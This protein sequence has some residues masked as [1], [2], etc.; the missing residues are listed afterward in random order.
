MKI[1]Y[2]LAQYF[3]SKAVIDKI[4]MPY[5]MYESY[6]DKIY[7]MEQWANIFKGVEVQKPHTWL[8]TGIKF[9]RRISE[10]EEDLTKVRSKEIYNFLTDKKY[11]T[12]QESFGYCIYTDII[13]NHPERSRPVMKSEQTILWSV[14]L[15]GTEDCVYYTKT[16]DSKE[17]GSIYVPEMILGEERHT[18]FSAAVSDLYW[19]DKSFVRADGVKR[20]GTLTDFMPKERE[21]EGLLTRLYADLSMFKDKGIR[22]CILL[23]GLPGTGKSTLVYNI[24]KNVSNRTLVLS[25]SIL[26]VDDYSISSLFL[27]LNPDMIIMDD[28]DRYSNAL[29]NNLSLF[30]EGYCNAPLIVFTSNHYH[31]LPD[32][33]KRPG[34]VDEIIEMQNPSKEIRYEIVRLLASR[35]GLDVPED[36]MEYL[37]EIHSQYPSAYILELLRRIKIHGWEYEIPPYDLTFKKLNTW[38]SKD[39]LCVGCGSSKKDC[40]CIYDS[41]EY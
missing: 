24:A 13:R 9:M 10:P 29:N 6:N 32:A 8:D 30:E 16:E 39:S 18:L 36:K 28:I 37:D 38:K 21:Y 23:Q 4:K 31:N 20:S 12:P 17:I 14:A 40:V 3:T 2:V 15:E 5:T 41:N 11:E 34:R 35:E 22:R 26:D 1:P 27:V 25:P 33:F 19:T 7:E